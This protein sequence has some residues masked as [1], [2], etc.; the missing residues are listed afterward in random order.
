[1]KTYDAIVI[2]DA[3]IDLVVVGASGMP[4]PGQEIFVEQMQVHVG[5]GAALFALNLAKLGLKLAFNG[6]LGN[7]YYGAFVKEQ[8]AHYGIDTSYI[9]TSTV[10]NTGISIAINP[11]KDRSFISYAGSNSELNLGTLNMDC[12]ALGRHVHLTGYK[13][14]QNHP[15]YMNLVA[16]LKELGVTLSCDVGWDDTGEW[17]EGIF[18]LA[19]HIDVFFMNETEALH[20]TRCATVRES[21]E[22]LARYGKH[23][24]VKLGSQGA[25]ASKGGTMTYRSG[26]TVESVDTTGAGDS[27][28]A[29]YVYGFL[30]G[31]D[32][33]ECLLYGNA[34]GA[35]S[36]QSYGGSTGVTDLGELERFIAEQVG[37]TTELWEE[38]I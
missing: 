7:D 6:V 36:V 9:A 4:L 8:F 17:Y 3:N 27:F 28:N 30:T 16:S 21:V 23:V 14:S 22:K 31:R 18:E 1:M 20:Y 24:V 19:R 33:G 32:V 38:A 37:K 2:G 25:V 35:F 10:N 29:G 15:E 11:E 5:G 34:C 12:V 13:G 26:F